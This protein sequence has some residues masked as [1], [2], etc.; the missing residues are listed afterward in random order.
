MPDPTFLIALAGALLGAASLVLHV[1]APRTENT[2][3]DALRDDIDEVLAFIRGQQPANPSS[4]AKLVPP[5]AAL[6]LVVALGGML[7]TACGAGQVAADTGTRIVDCTKL[8]AGRI[9]AVVAHLGEAELAYQLADTPVDWD[10][11]ETQAEAVGLAIGGCALGPLVA[12]RAPSSSSGAPARAAAA[13]T[14][15]SNDAAR[16]W[17]AFARLKAHAGVSTFQTSAGP[18]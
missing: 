14:P 8:D 16:A 10:A 3:D 9:A 6:L 5:A 18:L 7:L 15:P 1:V 11:I 2:I 13:A 4:A 12:A 17:A